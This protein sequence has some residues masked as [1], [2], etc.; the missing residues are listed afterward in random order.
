MRTVVREGVGATQGWPP[1]RGTFDT[2]A[3]RVQLVEA[4]VALPTVLGCPGK[5]VWATGRCGAKAGR[6]MLDEWLADF[7]FVEVS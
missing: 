3:G 6:D 1:A 4:L 7:K 5:P 2:K